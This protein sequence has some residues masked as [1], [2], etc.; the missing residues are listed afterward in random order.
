MDY[1]D[2]RVISALSVIGGVHISARALL[3]MKLIWF[4]Y[5]AR[6]SKKAE[7]KGKPSAII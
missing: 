5:I 3:D 1:C 4:V 6:L 7:K 2:H